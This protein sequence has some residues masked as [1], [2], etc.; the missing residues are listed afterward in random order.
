ME[1]LLK[2]LPETEGQPRIYRRNRNMIDRSSVASPLASLLASYI[3][4]YLA[5]P[6]DRNRNAA[7]SQQTASVHVVRPR[8]G[9]PMRVL[10]IVLRIALRG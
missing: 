9:V 7:H 5:L 1:A 2:Q 6:V 8:I 4:S 10:S 3:A